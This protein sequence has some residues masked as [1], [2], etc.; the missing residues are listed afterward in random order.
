MPRL[1]R[2]RPDIIFIEDNCEG[3]FG[4]YEGCYSGTSEASLCSAVSFYA[5]KTLTTGEGGAFFTNDNKIYEYIKSIYS[6]GMTNERY[7]HDKVAYNYR[8]TNIEAGFLYDQLNDLQH[9]LSLKEKIFKKYD[10]LLKKHINNGKIIKI[11]NEEN[12]VSATW[13]YCIIIR[14]K[15]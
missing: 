11:T 3:I 4:K 6:H 15:F 1:K 8:M 10:I 5:N 7:I 9:I 13:M 14:I 12:T 2:M